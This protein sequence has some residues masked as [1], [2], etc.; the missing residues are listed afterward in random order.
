M[1]IEKNPTPPN[2]NLLRNRIV[3]HVLDLI[4]LVTVVVQLPQ[5]IWNYFVQGKYRGTL[6]VRLWGRVMKR[7]GDIHCAWFEAA[8]LG[9]VRAL[10]SLVRAFQ[11]EHP[12]WYC[13][14]SASTTSGFRLAQQLFPDIYVF[15]LP[16]DFSWAV[17]TAVA[18]LR[19]NLLVIVDNEAKPNLLAAAHQHGSQVAI[20]NGRMTTKDMRLRVRLK[21]L[22]SQALHQVDLIMAQN[23][24]YANRFVRLG[25][26]PNRVQVVGSLK[27]DCLKRHHNDET[28]HELARRAQID[29]QDIVWMA[30]STHEGEEQT[31]L[32]VFQALQHQYPK[33]RLI[34]APRHIERTAAVE[35]LLARSGLPW[36]RSSH[37][38]SGDDL[39]DLNEI[40]G[41]SPPKKN[42]KIILVDTIGD[43]VWWWGVSHIA[44]VGGSLANGR[45][46]NMLE[47]AAYGAA[48]CFGPHTSDFRCFVNDL[49]GHGAARTVHNQ[50]E[51]RAFVAE[52]LDDTAF[53]E[54]LG[55]RA[56]ELI[57]QRRGATLKTL[58]TLKPLIDK[59]AIGETSDTFCRSELEH[60]VCF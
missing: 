54:Q 42:N 34:L 36:E 13:V 37:L 16:V 46:R 7:D 40:E 53:R 55:H 44:F 22:S 41:I 11:I 15:P 48:V 26:V 18:R 19:P 25:A 32:E 27:Y 14:I 10:E 35:H 47:P 21:W 12:G 29:S 1:N 4:Y 30:G 3:T 52:C 28:C 56:Q 45:G 51:L 50:L 57:T 23:N 59:K 9:E 24:A 60:S 2:S 43:V 31:I 6:G 8:S 58:R 39:R 17:R 33:L 49:L 38:P 20:V 5:C